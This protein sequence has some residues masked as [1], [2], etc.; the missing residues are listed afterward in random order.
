MLNVNLQGP[1]NY[2]SSFVDPKLFIRHCQVLEPLHL[3]QKAE[4][5]FHADSIQP[6]SR[7]LLNVNYALLSLL[8]V[9]NVGYPVPVASPQ[10]LNSD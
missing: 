9:L 3:H 4:F 2:S 1:L 6:A 5:S 8:E 7:D 10:A